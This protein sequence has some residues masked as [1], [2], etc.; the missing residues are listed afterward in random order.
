MR[1]VS[2]QASVG[3]ETFGVEIFIACSPKIVPANYRRAEPLQTEWVLLTSGSTGLPKLVVHTLASLTG[4]I[5]SGNAQAGHV[6]WPTFYDIR[7]YGGLQ[8]FLRA[9]LT[10]AS[11]VLSCS[12]EPTP[13]FLLRAGALNV[14]HISGTPSHWRRA[15]MSPSASGIAPQ[16]VRLSGEVADQTILDHLRSFYPEAVVSHAFASTEAGV[17]FEVRDGLAGI[18]RV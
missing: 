7:R 5:G 4:A 6:I 17:A 8:I 11:L 3:P 13:E 18:Q 2:D 16:Y 9:L 10:R 15:L 14:T 12:D 1:F